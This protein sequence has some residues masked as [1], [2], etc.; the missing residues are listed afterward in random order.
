MFLGFWES[1]HLTSRGDCTLESEKTKRRE[2][3]EQLLHPSISVPFSLQQLMMFFT[4]D[5]ICSSLF[6]FQSTVVNIIIMCYFLFRALFFFICSICARNGLLAGEELLSS[7]SSFGF[8]GPKEGK[9][10]EKERSTHLQHI[11]LVT[12]LQKKILE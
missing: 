11:I 10:K 9:E 3:L 4:V 2:R 8:H 7:F 5:S 1:I 12:A 6:S